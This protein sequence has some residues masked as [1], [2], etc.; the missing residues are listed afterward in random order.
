MQDTSN[1][2][3]VY[4]PASPVYMPPDQTLE[5]PAQPVAATSAATA[6]EFCEP[7]PA[8]PAETAKPKKQKIVREKTRF[9][10]PRCQA[11]KP[12]PASEMA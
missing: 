9:M 12:E 5:P 10:T 4:P 1:Q 8:A 6:D 7:E 11:K 3:L 2:Y